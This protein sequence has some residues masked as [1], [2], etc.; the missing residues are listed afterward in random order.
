MMFNAL[1]NSSDPPS[2]PPPRD[3]SVEGLDSKKG[4]SKMQTREDKQQEKANTSIPMIDSDDSSNIVYVRFKGVPPESAFGAIYRRSW[5]KE[6]PKAVFEA[7]ERLTGKVWPSSPFVNVSA[8][9]RSRYNRGENGWSVQLTF[10]SGEQAEKA[11]ECMKLKDPLKQYYELDNA[12]TN[13]NSNQYFKHVRL[14]G[15]YGMEPNAVVTMLNALGITAKEFKK[16]AGAPGVMFGWVLNKHLPEL[17]KIPRLIPTL[18]DCDLDERRSV[19]PQESY[20]AKV[21]VLAICYNCGNRG[22]YT[23]NCTKDTTGA[24]CIDC[25]GK[26][27][28]CSMRTEH[29]CWACKILGKSESIQENHSTYRC[30]NIYPNF[31]RIENYLS[32]S[33]TNR[34]DPR[35][36]PHAPY[37]QQSPTASSGSRWSNG[38]P[39]RYQQQPVGALQHRDENETIPS[40]Q[41]QQVNSKITELETRM[42]RLE[43]QLNEHKNDTNSRLDKIADMIRG[44]QHAQQAQQQQQQPRGKDRVQFTAT[45][46]RPKRTTRT[47]TA[48]T[49]AT[50]SSR[51]D[52]KKQRAATDNYATTDNELDSGGEPDNDQTDSSYASSPAEFHIKESLEFAVGKILQTPQRRRSARQNKELKHAQAAIVAMDTLD[53]DYE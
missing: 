28:R 21:P 27:L 3:E 32:P 44:L 1:P 52:G 23:S 8:E 30:H 50:P 40:T 4:V 43:T 33:K 13:P 24:Q 12:P 41:D 25:G 7:F 47:T 9:P 48:E 38:P 19:A 31:A 42:Q 22:H 49:L 18:L 45:S 5:E 15:I 14:A 11:R 29:S 17:A 26:H 16:G 10:P 36:Q 34:V 53:D 37:F 6:L 39:T 35:Q 2:Q 20:V 51:R 46:Q